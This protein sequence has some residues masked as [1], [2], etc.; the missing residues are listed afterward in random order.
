M[1]LEFNPPFFYM[2]VHE[3][4]FNFI[5]SV[6]YV[7]PQFMKNHVPY[8]PRHLPV[9]VEDKHE[10]TLLT[11]SILRIMRGYRAERSKEET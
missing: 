11:A 9:I 3:H 7:F 1:S 2:S 6:E 10:D 8:N 4:P 5:R